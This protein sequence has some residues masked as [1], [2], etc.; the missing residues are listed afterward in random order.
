M[1]YKTD[2]VPIKCWAE[3]DQPREKFFLKGKAHLTD[4]ELL[5]I[6][7]NSGN[8][9]ETA[10]DLARRILNKYN[11]DLI[12]MSN[13]S[14]EDLK[15]FDGV[16]KV[17]AITILAGLELGKRREL[18]IAKDKIKIT[19]SKDAFKIVAPFL[20]DIPHEEFWILLLN[21]ANRLLDKICISRGGISGTVVDARLIFK[22]AINQL[23]SGIILCHNH[24]SGN[25]KP[26]KADT[27]ITRKIKEAAIHLDIAILDHIIIGGDQFLSFADE[28]IL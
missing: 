4:A 16:G 7:L 15:Q 13:S 23:A 24:P 6:L 14:I 5:A 9:H 12:L 11:H 17:K 28:G 25:L 21:R 3:S 2:T 8:R 20:R 27:A 18:F 19:S 10:L 1:Q 22:P 26:S